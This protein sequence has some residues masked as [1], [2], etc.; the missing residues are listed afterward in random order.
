[1]KVATYDHHHLLPF[2]HTPVNPEYLFKKSDLNGWTY[3]GRVHQDKPMTKLPALEH[4]IMPVFDGLVL[5]DLPVMAHV[6]FVFDE[7]KRMIERP[8]RIWVQISTEPIEWTE[9]ELP[10]IVKEGKVQVESLWSCADTS[11]DP[12]NLLPYGYDQEKAKTPEFWRDFFHAQ[13]LQ[14]KAEAIKE[15]NEAM[16]EA[17]RLVR[18]YAVIPS[19]TK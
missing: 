14:A 12:F 10:I 19:L 4:W 13:L 5:L 1:M 2:W 8:K 16:A 18:A 7:E 3:L 17:E 15:V 9:T 6:S 11:Y